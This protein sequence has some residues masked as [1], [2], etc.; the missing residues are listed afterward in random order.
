MVGIYRHHHAGGQV[1]VRASSPRSLG[2]RPDLRNEPSRPCICPCARTQRRCALQ[3]KMT[4][5]KVCR[6]M[7]FILRT[8][9]YPGQRFPTRRATW[10][11]L[12]NGSAEGIEE[13]IRTAQKKAAPTLGLTCSVRWESSETSVSPDLHA[14]TEDNR[15]RSVFAH[16]TGIDTL[17]FPIVLGKEARETTVNIERVGTDHDALHFC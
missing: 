5:A 10:D 7:A 2:V 9:Y 8:G 14:V 12:R 11:T 16:H 1:G 3:V 15:F 6:A 4:A 17:Q 13:K